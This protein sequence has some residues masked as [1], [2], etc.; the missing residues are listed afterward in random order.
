MSHFFFASFQVQKNDF[1]S[2]KLSS[3]EIKSISHAYLMLIY[4]TENKLGQLLNFMVTENYISFRLKIN[5]DFLNEFQ[6][7]FK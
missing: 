1:F 4:Q 3:G 6:I 2:L 7:V 5:D